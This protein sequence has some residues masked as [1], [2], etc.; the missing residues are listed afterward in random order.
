M[1]RK[2]RTD[3]FELVY[4]IIN[5]A[6]QSYKGVIPDEYWKEPYMSKDELKNEIEEGV[7]FW[8][9]EEEG[10]IFGVMGIQRKH[11]INLIRHA[12]VCPAK[13][14]HGIGG[15]LLTYL[16]DLTTKPILIATWLGATW[17]IQFYKKYGFKLVSC[18]DGVRLQRKYWSTPELKIKSSVVLADKRWLKIKL[19]EC[20]KSIDSF[21]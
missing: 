17:A 8:V 14:N 21:S 5:E 1:I 9:Y 7:E 19:N 2:S 6:A 13:Q 16:Q 12:Y 10:K 11:D 4:K 3:D 15:K 18:E 20:T